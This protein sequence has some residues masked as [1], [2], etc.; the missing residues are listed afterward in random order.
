MKAISS[1]GNAF[2]KQLLKLSDSAAQ[3]RSEGV[4]L[5]DGVH[6]IEAYRAALGPPK[7]LIVSESAEENAEIKFLL[8][9]F[10]IEGAPAPT[11]LSDALFREVSSLKTPSGVL[12]L[13][14][15]PEP[16]AIRVHPGPDFRVLLEAIQDPGN[17]GS[18]LRSAAAAGAGDVY[19]SPGCADMW[20][21]KALRTAMGAHFKLR[22]HEHADLPSIARVFDG[23]VVATTLNAKKSL[24]A[25]K[26]TGPVAFAF[27]NEGQGLSASL[28]KAV[29]EKV[30]I[31]MPGGME[32]LNAAA[33]AAACFFERV[34]QLE[35]AAR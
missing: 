18:I 26:L 31:P 15:V 22:L 5:L 21:P 14:A 30:R 27:G 29:G 28:Q 35:A 11:V 2:F 13:I 8:R 19:L 9:R 33:A 4:T 32:S 25:L 17:I 6:L 7:S 1:R 16:S 3:R 23:T 20:S 12:A 34:R 10:A 24:Y